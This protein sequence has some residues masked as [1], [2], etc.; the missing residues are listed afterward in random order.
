MRPSVYNYDN[1]RLFLRD[2][3]NHLKENDSVFSYRVF[4][5]R[6]GFSSPNFLKLLV[7]GKRNVSVLGIQKVA[8]GLELSS[9][10]S[11]FLTKLVS[12]NQAKDQDEKEIYF[13]GLSKNR[14][15][16]R[17]KRLDKSQFKYYSKWYYSVIRELV[18]THNFSEDPQWISRAL[19]HEISPRESQ[20]ALNF[21]L[22]LNM[23]T[24]NEQGHLVQTETLIE[25]GE[26]VKSLALKAFHHQM[27]ERA[28]V[29]LE[30][31]KPDRRDIS[32]I[33]LGVSKEI[34]PELKRRIIAF[35]KELLDVIGSSQQKTDEVVQ[36]N[37]QLLSL[38]H[39][40]NG[41]EK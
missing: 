35:R 3:F 32:A 16:S 17:I 36:L 30:K 5:K 10:E 4:A 34:L 9:T 1:Y 31:S 15:F 14:Q 11:D 22:K 18:A 28:S 21:L 8:K 37:I 7:E 26:E 20:S 41:D 23:I 13:R 27:L 25:S 24:R 2:Y 38:A 33:T 12:F 39:S 29:A 6:A 40:F 19:N